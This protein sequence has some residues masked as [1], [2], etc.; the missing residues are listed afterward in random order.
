MMET[1][2]LISTLSLLIFTVFFC[3]VIIDFNRKVNCLNKKLIKKN[4]HLKEENNKI[5]QILRRIQILVRVIKHYRIIKNLEYI[6][7]LIKVLSS[8]VV[9]KK[10]S[11]IK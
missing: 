7:N 3:C 2:Y 11:N 6:L 10:I 9:L 1:I 4:K 8:Y 5:M